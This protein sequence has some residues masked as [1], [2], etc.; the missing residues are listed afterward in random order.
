MFTTQEELYAALARQGIPQRMWPGLGRYVFDHTRPGSFWVA[1]LSNDFM[2]AVGTADEE[3]FSILKLYASFLYNEMPSR[4]ARPAM[5]G[6]REIVEA[7]VGH[8]RK[9]G[10]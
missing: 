3:N 6:S 4:A 7:W 10:S 1:V 8:P 5:W 2:E 9:S